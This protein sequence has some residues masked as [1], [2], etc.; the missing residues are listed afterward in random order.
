VIFGDIPIGSGLLEYAEQY[1]VE[2]VADLKKY[3]GKSREKAE[4]LLSSFLSTV[5]TWTSDNVKLVMSYYESPLMHIPEYL[6]DLEIEP[7]SIELRYVEDI[8]KVFEIFARE[9]WERIYYHALDV[10]YNS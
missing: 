1:A 9:I 7:T 10:V 6:R 3:Q 4:E 5:M 2:T 8:E